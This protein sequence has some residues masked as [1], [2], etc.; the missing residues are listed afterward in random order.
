MV[1]RVIEDAVIFHNIYFN[2]LT[3]EF[4]VKNDTFS[5]SAFSPSGSVETAI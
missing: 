1:H 5:I 3:A 4:A 2:K